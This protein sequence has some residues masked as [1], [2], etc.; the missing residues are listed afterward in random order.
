M[1][2]KSFHFQ[3]RWKE[4]LVVSGNGGSFVL[5]MPIGV[6]SVYLPT[7]TEW[8]RRAPDWAKR[9]WPILRLELEDWCQENHAKFYIDHTAG[10]Y[11]V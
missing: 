6:L 5:E 7:E 10:I 2:E 8:E 4:E 3:T 1:A 9:L 11:P